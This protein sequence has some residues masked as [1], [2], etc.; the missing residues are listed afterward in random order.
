MS[1]QSSINV[2]ASGSSPVATF[3]Q[4]Q[5]GS[6]VYVQQASV[7]DPSTGQGAP[8]DTNG[9]HVVLSVG[10]LQVWGGPLSASA[11]A[12]GASAT[13][14][15]T[16]TN[17]YTGTLQHG[18]FASTQPTQWALQIVNNSGTPTTITQFLTSA[19][20]TYDYKPGSIGEVPT[21]LSNG[22]AKYQVVATNL[23]TNSN[24]TATVYATF[25]W[26]EN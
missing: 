13:L 15:S 6:T 16:V 7:V 26:A 5:G 20:E 25:F 14:N 17:G 8:V 4:T 10:A 21:V 2:T 11:I 19:N 24:E 23:S 1:T 9:L 3:T 22:N 12:N 18:I